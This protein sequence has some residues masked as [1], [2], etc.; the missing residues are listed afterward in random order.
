MPDDFFLLVNKPVGISSQQCLNILKKKF[1]FKKLGHHGTLDPF[2]SGLLLVGVGE[3]TKFFPY[4]NDALKTYV[5]E[6]KLGEQ[7]DTM[8]HTGHITGTR[9]VP[10]LESGDILKVFKSL[11]GKISQIPPM[12]SAIK[13]DG[14]PLY[15]L[16]R[17]GQVV[18]REAREVHVESLECLQF[19]PPFLQF[20]AVVSRGTYIRVL[21]EQIAEALG[22]VGHL[23]KLCRRALVGKNLSAATDAEKNEFRPIPIA[24]ILSHLPSIF[25]SQEQAALFKNGRS[26]GDLDFSVSGQGPCPVLVFCKKDFL[27]VGLWQSSGLLSPLRLMSSH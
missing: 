15:K 22:T 20:E 9:E 25:I 17:Q 26:L 13:K 12:Y 1:S 5:A 6:L 18:E 2:A 7:T 3:A 8:D 19:S 11:T 21:G 23:T 24:E 4:V 16:A 10:V 14:Q 27:G